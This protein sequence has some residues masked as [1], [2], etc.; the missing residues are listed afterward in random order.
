[1]DNEL[2]AIKG[3]FKYEKFRTDN[4][5][6]YSFK[7]YD[8]SEKNITVVG[9]IP[10]VQKDILYEVKG[11][12]INHK[13]YGLQFQANI[14]EPVALNDSENLI[15]YLSSTSFKG[16][17][18]K[19]AKQIVEHFGKDFIAKMKSNPEIIKQV[20]FLSDKQIQT[21]EEVILNNDIDEFEENLQFFTLLGLTYNQ[22]LKINVFYGRNAKNILCKNPYKLVYDIN[23]FSFE[24]AD[25]L[26]K[27]L[28]TDISD[29]YRIE[30]YIVSSVMK[31]SMDQG[32]TY[33]NYEDIYEYIVKHKNI[34]EVNFINALKYA[35]DEK[36]LH[37]FNNC[38]YHKTQYDAEIF[39]AV[40]LKGFI[41][42]KEITI[43]HNILN[44]LIDNY[45]KANIIEY[46]QKQRDAIDNFFNHR[47]SIVTGGP[48]TGKT[49]VVKAMAYLAKKIYPDYNIICIAPTGRAS[50]RLKE[51]CGI[52]AQTIHSLLA[53]NMET[54]DFKKNIND[55]INYD[56][57][58]VD[59]SSMID[60][61][62]FY[63]LLNA[64]PNVK[65]ICM[66]GDV[67]QLPSV[68]PG[69][70]LYDLI[71]SDYFNVVKLDT[72]YRQK[73][74]S[75][76]LDLAN[77]I[78]NKDYNFTNEYQDI[79]L[80]DFPKDRVLMNLENII[81]KALDKG[82]SFKDIIVLSPMYRGQLGIDSVNNVL[83]QRFNPPSDTKKEVTLNMKLFREHDRIL[84]LKNQPDD[85]VYNGDIG[86][87]VEIIYPNSD[88][89]KVRLV[90]DFDGNKV[91][92][93]YDNIVNITHAYCISIH[94]SQ[95]SEYPIVILA[96]GEN[97]KFM[98]SNKLIY[99]AI[100][101]AKRSLIL[102]T[103]KELFIRAYLTEDKIRNTNL[104]L[105]LNEY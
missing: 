30:A 55:P 21:I 73:E 70:I 59:E 12:F 71:E 62:L 6:V 75:D 77:I 42:K 85:D 25:K 16:V 60:S 82:Y 68:S 44:G 38:I 100:T 66:I 11:I 27:K 49:T 19:A 91:E 64:A 51:L 52:N 102:L 69:E 7:M 94:K 29:L 89:K 41:D 93:N 83:Q 22:V 90:V 18:K 99:T 86:E 39:I 48:G 101:R 95:G 57:V 87:L 33:I 88:D 65:K 79:K 26:A 72:V 9:N 45:E 36:Y 105:F 2:E 98:F 20:K 92:Y 17:G 97:S 13:T 54:N 96:L 43:D 74:G 67:N 78:K 80:Y 10:N 58:I 61:W 3:H 31:L 84:Q 63:N 103:N 34:D 104:Q 15:K 81:E 40:Y 4:Y 28:D 46:S 8:K 37:R 5:A 56:I 50:K 76:I 35:I 1:M 14:V 23:G 47:F 32:S 53:Y 24:T